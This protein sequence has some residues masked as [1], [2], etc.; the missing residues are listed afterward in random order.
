MNA[1]IYQA[2]LLCEPCGNKVYLQLQGNLKNDPDYWN[3]DTFPQG[4]Y[5]DGGGEAD[6]PNHCG[7]CGLFLENP[8]TQDGYEYVHEI[9]DNHTKACE[10]QV[11]DEW[12]DF[13]AIPA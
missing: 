4:P 8:L 13:Y 11:V 10:C 2:E 5:P 3:S 9:V 1:Y 12:A 6:T 7:T